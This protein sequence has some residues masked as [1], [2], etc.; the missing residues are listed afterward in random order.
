MQKRAEITGEAL[1]FAA[2]TEFIRVGY[3]H[4]RLDTI[5]TG[6]NVSRGALYDHFG[7]K[8]ELARAVI[9]AGSTRFRI[10]CRPLLQ[11]PVPAFDAL[12]GI[13]CLLLDPAVTDVTFQA[14]FHLLTE[15]P[16]RPGGNP[17]LL[18]T[19]LSDYRELA[20]RALAEGDLRAEDPDTIASLLVD[21]FVGV[22]LLS[23]VTGRVD[24][25]PAR[26]TGAWG[27][28]LPG[29]VEPTRLDHFRR[30]VTRHVARA[31]GRGP[32]SPLSASPCSPRQPN[33]GKRPAP[34]TRPRRQG[35]PP[36]VMHH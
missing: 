8:D 33:N 29:L 13:S 28:L 21:T 27:L 15:H 11:A 19:W 12:I 2:A 10:A 7:S 9:E 30:L 36:T 4:A 14:T 34:L 32:A 6:A 35:E 17:T 20:R 26:L 23:A 24:D 16:D 22:Y 1:L 5:V 3:A 25:L 31:R 18:A